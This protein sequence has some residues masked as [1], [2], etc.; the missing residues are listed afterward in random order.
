[1][2]ASITE[3]SYFEDLRAGGQIS[4]HRPPGLPPATWKRNE[5]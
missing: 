5:D 4:R 3:D 1:M 2:T